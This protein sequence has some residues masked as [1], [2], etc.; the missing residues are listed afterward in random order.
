MALNAGWAYTERVEPGSDGRSVLAHYAAS[1][2]HSSL[3]EWDARI[4]RG[5]VELDGVCAD[6][7]V[8][9]RP[10]QTLVW[11]RPPWEEPEAPMHYEVLHEDEAIVAA[12]KPSGLPTM[13]AGGFL[14]HTLMALVRRNYPEASPLHRIGRFTSGIVLFARTNEAASLISRVAGPS[15]EEAVPRARQRRRH[16]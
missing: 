5:E 16:E 15:G 12:I 7:N 9:L 13:P 10:G 4:R 3:Q 14:E 2:R 6:A 1:H 8:I 11:H